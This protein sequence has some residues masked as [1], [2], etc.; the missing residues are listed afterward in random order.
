[1]EHDVYTAIHAARLITGFLYNLLCSTDC[2]AQLE[3]SQPVLMIVLQS[4]HSTFICGL[5]KLP[6]LTSNSLQRCHSAIVEL[7]VTCQINLL[8]YFIFD[9]LV[10]E[11]TLLILLIENR[12][13]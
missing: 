11:R 3:I 12:E 13:V 8:I 7:I 10:T 6:R 9:Q 2:I 5:L 1:M 4:I